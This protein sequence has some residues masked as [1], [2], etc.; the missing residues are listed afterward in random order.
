LIDGL[1]KVA[2]CEPAKLV[3]AISASSLTFESARAVGN[4][5]TL[6]EI[7]KELGF[8]DLRRVFR[9]TRHTIDVEAFIRIIVLNRL[10]GPDSKLVVLRWLQTVSLPDIEVKAVTHQQL[11]RSMD[12]LMN[13]QDA[14]YGVVA[15]LLRPLVDRDLSLAFYDM[16]QL[17]KRQGS[18]VPDVMYTLSEPQPYI[19]GGT[20]IWLDGGF[21]ELIEDTYS[22]RRWP[23]TLLVEVTVTHGIE[24]MKLGRI[25]E[26]DM[27]TLEI[28]IGS[29]GGRV[30]REGL[31]NLVVNEIILTFM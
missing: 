21:E 6:T 7:W 18:I 30:T 4:V 15:G 22:S 19:Y 31:R 9:R 12:A 17:E 29:M 14:V 27:P 23:Q 26:L 16:T 28:N 2:G 8:S 1:L 10:C 25:Q 11:L 13:N 5:W 24:R 20:E 3:P